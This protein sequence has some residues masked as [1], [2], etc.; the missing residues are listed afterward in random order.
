MIQTWRMIYLEL[1][2]DSLDNRHLLFLLRATLRVDGQ[3][4][5]KCSFVA[6]R[7]IW[8][9]CKSTRYV[10]NPNPEEIMSGTI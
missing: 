8:F 1:V 7:S 6:H 4:R 9:I 10:K 3:E 2:D 5:G